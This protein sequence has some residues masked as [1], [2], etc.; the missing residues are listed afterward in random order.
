MTENLLFQLQ[1]QIAIITFNRPNVLN[2]FQGVMFKQLL[3]MIDKVTQ[4]DSIRALLLTGTGRAFSA[5]IDL[6]ELSHDL[7]GANVSDAQRE[8]LDDLQEITRRL[9]NLQKPVI[10]ALNGLA[11]GAGAEIAIASDIRIASENAYFQF[12]EVKRGLMETNG[13]MYRLPRFVGMGRAAHILLTGDRLPAQSALEMGLVTKVVPLEQVL[14]AGMEI[15][16]TLA[17]NAPISLRLIKQVLNQS[18]DLNLEQVMQLETDG[19]LECFA[20]EDMLEGVRAFLE[21][22]T[23][24]YKGK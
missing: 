16:N 14:Q 4:E 10:S 18:Y 3:G 20:S 24:I 8:V 5:G 19:M 6:A 9:V 15:A 13:V 23:P 21:K 22:R 1:G 7:D 12:T 2:A 11:V 17:A